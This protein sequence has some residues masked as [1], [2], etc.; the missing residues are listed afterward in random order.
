MDKH[1]ISQHYDDLDRAIDDV[2]NLLDEWL[3]EFGE[4][5]VSTWPSTPSSGDPPAG[6]SVPDRVEEKPV[7]PVRGDD[8]HPSGRPSVVRYAQV[9]LHEWLANLVQ[10][11]DFDSRTPV[12]HIRIRANDRNI[13]CAVTDNSTG[14]DLSAQLVTQR[15]EARALPERG[16]GLRI[17]SACTDQCSYR[18]TDCGQYRF[19]FSIPVDHEPWL[20]ML[21]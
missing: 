5:P 19:E 18:P 1:S 10:H 7:P 4:D 2:R 11:A 12:V 21:F 20:S 14:F 3:E 17:I 16:M 13:S 9:V 6:D 8:S 15:K